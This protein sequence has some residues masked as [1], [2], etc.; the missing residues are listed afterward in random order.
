MSEAS[1]WSWRTDENSDD[2]P[3]SFELDIFK[4]ADGISRNLF[5]L[6]DLRNMLSTDLPP[7]AKAAQDILVNLGSGGG[8]AQGGAA[9]DDTL[10]GSG[11]NDDLF[12]GGGNDTL[13]GSGGADFLRAG[14][15]DDILAAGS[16]DDD[17][18][19]G[20]GADELD[21]SSA[22]LSVVVNISQGVATGADIGADQFS[23]IEHATGGLGADRIT[24]DR[25]ANRLLGQ[26]GDDLLEG[27]DGD[28]SLNG[29]T[30]NDTLQGGAGFDTMNGE[31]GDDIY[32]V[33]E[34]GDYL[35]ENEG[36]GTDRIY[37]SISY[38]LNANV[39]EL[40]LSGTAAVNATGNALDNLIY[41][42]SAANI[43]NGALGNDNMVGGLGD[44][45]YYV[46]EA[47]DYLVE[48]A[49]AG[50]DR[51]YSSISYSLNANVEQ[52]VL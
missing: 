16:G 25:G 14:E 51:V 27:G 8:G 37:S 3:G 36:G 42:N 30:G 10:V 1:D 52:L 50:T 44:D 34:A 20:H 38:T 17:I 4:F 21:Y 31:G 47:A 39:E 32:Y 19:G 35:V 24:G 33:G 2:Y 13:V 46:G 5:D 40:V 26:A 9:G 45:V 6:F 49:G 15:G 7:E 11:A 12:G 23:G 22:L 29:G 41:G 48:N 43:L 28:D 18:N